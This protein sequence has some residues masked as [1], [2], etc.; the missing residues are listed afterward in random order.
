MTRDR[1]AAIPYITGG[2]ILHL[3]VVLT[4][5]FSDTILNQAGLLGV[6]IAAIIGGWFGATAVRRLGHAAAGGL[7]VSGISAFLGILL[8]V[9]LGDKHWLVLIF[10]TLAA[11][12]TGMIAA[13]ILFV[14][15]GGR[16]ADENQSI[17]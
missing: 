7:V 1:I 2:M 14:A 13:M 15:T 3:A 10:G 6:F 11:A 4:A 12:I 17:T 9:I 16:P 8:A 5:H